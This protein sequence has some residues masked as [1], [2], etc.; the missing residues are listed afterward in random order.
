MAPLRLIRVL[1]PQYAV[2]GHGIELL[3][4]F[5]LETS[6]L[7]SVKWFKD[8]QEFFRY[9]PAAQDQ[10]QVFAPA[11]LTVDVSVASDAG[12]AVKLQKFRGK[13]RPMLETSFEE[14]PFL[15]LLKKKRF[16]R[17]HKLDA[18]N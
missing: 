2:R 3:C 6:T 7:Y 16:N 4:E 8:D 15:R 17:W 1:I 14:L 18:P 5:D 12:R 10:Y 11:G 13:L 9:I